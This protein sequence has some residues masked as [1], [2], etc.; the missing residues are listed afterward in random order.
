MSGLTTVE[1]EVEP[2]PTLSFV[3]LEATVE[4]DYFADSG[5]DC[6]GAI[7]KL[8]LASHSRIEISNTPK[9][10]NGNDVLDSSELSCCRRGDAHSTRYNST[11]LI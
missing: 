9:E 4:P 11:P 7:L 10:T 1:A 5:F 3:V 8:F 2:D 6:F